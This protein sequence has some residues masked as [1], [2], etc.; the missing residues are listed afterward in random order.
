MTGSYKPTLQ[1]LRSW[2]DKEKGDLPLHD[3]LVCPDDGGLDVDG[4]V[5]HS[6]QLHGLLQSSHHEQSVVSLCLGKHR[7]HVGA[8]TASWLRVARD[9]ANLR[10][11]RWAR[12]GGGSP[13]SPSLPTPSACP[14]SSAWS[15]SDRTGEPPRRSRCSNRC[16]C[17]RCAPRSA[18]ATRERQNAN[19]VSNACTAT[20]NKLSLRSLI[21]HR[22][23]LKARQKRRRRFIFLLFTG[24]W[25]V[26]IWW[27]IKLIRP[28]S[29]IVQK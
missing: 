14:R 19:T 26:G 9:H 29:K 10:W 7:G 16:R 13:G 12:C 24:F 17:E 8:Q 15:W 18:G 25:F 21:R 11:H 23:T 4:M 28:H 3:A 27:I 20:G 1:S 22:Y 6:P 2:R 5:P